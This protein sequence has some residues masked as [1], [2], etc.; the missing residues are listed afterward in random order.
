[1][2][3]FLCTSLFVAGACQGGPNYPDGP[4]AIVE[5]P[6]PVDSSE[7]ASGHDGGTEASTEAALSAPFDVLGKSCAKDERERPAYISCDPHG[8]VSGVSAEPTPAT[9]ALPVP[10]VRTVHKAVDVGPPPGRTLEVGIAGNLVAIRFVIC[11]SCPRP[12]GF[13]FV[14][15]FSRLTDSDLAQLQ[16]RIGL[17]PKTLPL[18]SYDDWKRALESDGG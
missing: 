11:S 6:A 7:P 5:V 10:G 15:D 3:R 17:P 4:S 1:V 8:L 13:T 18:R 9:E 14:G 12:N 2:K 16:Q